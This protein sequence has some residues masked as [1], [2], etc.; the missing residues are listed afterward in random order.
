MVEPVWLRLVFAYVRIVVRAIICAV[1]KPRHR[2]TLPAVQVLA[3]DK[4]CTQQ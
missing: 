2:A 1:G 3:P 4:H